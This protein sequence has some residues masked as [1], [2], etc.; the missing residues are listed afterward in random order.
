MTKIISN[1]VQQLMQRHNINDVP[2]LKYNYVDTEA[3]LRHIR[4]TLPPVRTPCQFHFKNIPKIP[5]KPKDCCRIRPYQL[6]VVNEVVDVRQGIVES[7]LIVMPCGS[8]KTFTSCCILCRVKRRSLIITNYKIV[9]NQWKKELMKNFTIDESR[10]QCIFD[11][12]F[13]FDVKDPP[14][15][16]IITYDTLTLISSSASRQLLTG[17]LSIDFS[18]IIIDEA[19]KAVAPNYFS[20]I[21][22]L[23]GC[24][25]ALTA[26]PVREDSDIQLLKQLVSKE[27]IISATS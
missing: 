12:T 8:G 5:I 1:G 18:I 7:T 19:H 6:Q 4:C 15:F 27:K 25:I 9:A 11:D 22:R 26:T 3:F 14:D 10:I 16:T 23:S 24:F 17:L 20:V 13:K 2:C 21:I